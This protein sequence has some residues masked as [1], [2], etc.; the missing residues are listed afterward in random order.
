VC[1]MRCLFRFSAC[2]CCVVFN[3]GCVCVRACVHNRGVRACTCAN[4]ALRALSGN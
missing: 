4:H 3:V 2:G 1:I